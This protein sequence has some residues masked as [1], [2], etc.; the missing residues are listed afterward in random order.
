MNGDIHVGD[1]IQQSGAGCIGKLQ[2]Q[3]SGN[4]AAELREMINLAAEL[5]K[6]ASAADR[7]VIDESV[8][9]VRDGERAAPGALRE[10]VGSLITVAA[11][12]GH[13]GIPLLD[14]ALKVKALFSL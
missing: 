1:S 11:K 13:A 12:A 6:R 2:Y 9:V 5:R 7:T 10:A 4:P 14:V 3:G 8:D